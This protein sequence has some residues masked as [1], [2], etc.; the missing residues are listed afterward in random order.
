[1]RIAVDVMGADHGSGVI[2]DGTRMA[3]EA[4]PGITELLLVGDEEQIS[5]HCSKS[6]FKDPRVRIV[7]ASQVLTM[8]DKP[9]DALRKKKDCSIARAIEQVKSGDADAVVSPGNTGG[10]LSAGTIRLR[11][12]PGIS[13]AAIATVIPEPENEFVLLDAGANTECKGLHLAEFGVMGSIYSQQILGK[14]KPRVGVLSNGTEEMKGNELTQD[15]HRILSRLDL[16]Y[17]GNVEGHDLFK[18]RVDVV[19]ADGFVG[20]IVLKTC[21]SMAKAMFAWLKTELTANPKRKLGALLAKEAFKS[22]KHKLDAENYGGAPLLGLKGI[23][24]KAHASA[25][26]RAIMNAVHTATTALEADMNA[27]ITSEMEKAVDILEEVR[28][29]QNDTEK[30]AV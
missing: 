21:E 24:I 2:V 12:L 29:S 19:V 26:E 23:V 16:N 4:N 8:E 3:L 14:P 7:H 25:S 20:N 1:M 28:K 10:I 18:N 6:G 15:A 13:R 11:A 9:I 27:K 17:I 30:V 5:T 22:L